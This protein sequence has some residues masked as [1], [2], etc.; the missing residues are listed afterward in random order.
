MILLFAAIPSLAQDA[1][2]EERLPG[3]AVSVPH[4]APQQAAPSRE[5][6][7]IQGSAIEAIG[8][9]TGV[10]AGMASV[11]GPDGGTHAFTGS[12]DVVWDRYK[13]SVAVPVTA[14]RADQGYRGGLGNLRATGAWLAPGPDPEWQV[15]ATVTLGTGQAYTW[16]N[17]AHEL[18]PDSGIDLV[19]LRR[20]GDG[21]LRGAVRTGLGVHL[22]SGWAPYPDVFARVNLA[23][24]VEQRIADTVGVV[25]EASITWWDVSPVDATAMLWTEPMEGLRLRSGFTFPVA[26]WAGWQPANVPAGLR[27]STF[28]LELVAR[29]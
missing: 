23:G 15:G 18:W 4:A 11:L 10:S 17:E 8:G 14:Y 6:F 26:S 19:Y 27:E 22:P 12:A 29:H 1:P 20:L 21:D 16:V 13:V 7:G 3:E 24:L 25:A 9:G 28:R 5:R 2:W